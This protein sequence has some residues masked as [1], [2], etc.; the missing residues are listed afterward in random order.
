MWS[1]IDGN[2]GIVLPHY[3]LFVGLSVALKPSDHNSSYLNGLAC[4]W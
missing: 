3:L 1:R 4:S 2:H